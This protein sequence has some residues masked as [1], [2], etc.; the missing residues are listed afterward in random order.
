M[1]VVFKNKKYKAIFTDH[2]IIQMD[3]RN[4]SELN[5]LEVIEYGEVK[6]KEVENKYWVF[7]S[8]KGRK[9]NFISVSI[10]V[11]TPNLIVITTMI[12]WRPK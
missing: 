7:K 4:L 6:H 3:L 2:A 11:E 1:Q 5:V 8:L 12:N 10:A 9:D